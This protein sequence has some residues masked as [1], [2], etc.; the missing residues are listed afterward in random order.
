VT[1]SPV[2]AIVLLGVKVRSPALL[3]TLTSK[4]AARETDARVAV[5]RRVEKCMLL[6]WFERL[7]R[8]GYQSTEMGYMRDIIERSGKVKIVLGL[9][10]CSECVEMS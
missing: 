7:A 5:V 10:E 8:D 3:E 4:F 1:V 9:P 6:V 2:L